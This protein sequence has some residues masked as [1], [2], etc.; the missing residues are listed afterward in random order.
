M[1]A[2]F[3][4]CQVTPDIPHMNMP[5]FVEDI[6]ELGCSVDCA[7]VA[8][9]NP[10]AGVAFLRK[11]RPDVVVF[12]Q[13][14]AAGFIN[15]LKRSF[16]GT[17]F[18]TGGSGCWDVFLK[19]AAEYAVI[20]PG[21]AAIRELI[22]GLIAGA[23]VCRS[24]NTFFKKRRGR[25]MIIDHTGVD[26]AFDLRTEVLPYRPWLYWSYLG[27][28]PHLRPGS[29][30]ASPAPLIIDAG[31]PHRRR[32]TG[33]PFVAEDT[34]AQGY[35]LT[36]AASQR[37]RSIARQRQ[38]GCSFCTYP[39]SYA[40]STAAE[41][42][43]VVLEQA[44]YLQQHY[45]YERFALNSEYPFPFLDALVEGLVHS[46]LRIKQLNLRSRPDWLLRHR[47]MLRRAAVAARKNRFRLTVWQVGFE[48]FLQKDL[49]LY[50][51]GLKVQ[52]NIRALQ[53]LNLFQA[54]FPGTFSHC[55]HG[56]IGIHPWTSAADLSASMRLMRKHRAL[57]YS[58]PLADARLCLYD[59]FMP[60]YQRARAE[61]LL[62]RR[63]EQ[64]DRFCLADKRVRR[65][66]A[67]FERARQMVAAA[68]AASANTLV[69][70]AGW[71]MLLNRIQ[72]RIADMLAKGDE[73]KRMPTRDF[74]VAE[75]RRM[76]QCR[77]MVSGYKESRWKKLS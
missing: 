4:Q 37:I 39:G 49:D 13:E 40:R 11:H 28:A 56:F 46:G 14:F 53:M 51:K 3:L 29:R 24:A 72:L 6:R 60:V 31:C 66:I 74:L 16:P 8:A 5:L 44:A 7:C 20:G 55:S 38:S 52:T 69:K 75:A 26:A 21:R 36:P 43:A 57:R 73:N 17:V 15:R 45:G 70:Q 50:R 65:F 19:S 68:S 1:N 62:E 42:V 35:V 2:V 61:G 12:D 18:I 32:V 63:S 27:F 41:T 25:R 71:D 59:S 9:G 33:T 48:S 77:M 67:V 58:F 23:R 54:Q 76:I 47:A 10:G 34:M 22:G 64:R 30:P